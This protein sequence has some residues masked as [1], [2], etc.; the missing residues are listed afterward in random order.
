MKK[1]IFNQDI[2]SDTINSTD[3]QGKQEFSE[4][5][6]LH[7]DLEVETVPLEG[8]LLDQQFEHIVKPHSSLWKTGLKLTALLFLGAVV[9]Q[10]VQWLW[11]SFHAHQWISLAFA[12]VSFSLVIFGITAFFNEWRRLVKLKKRAQLQQDSQHF[13]AKQARFEQAENPPTAEQTVEFCLTVAKNLHFDAQSPSIELW[14]RQINESYSPQEISRLFSRNVLSP[15]DQ[16]AKKLIM[17]SATESAV[18]VAISP[19]A[20]VDMVFLGWRNLRL[21]NQIAALYGIEL[22]YFSRL[23]L[24]RMIL[25]NMAF[26]GATELLQEIGMDWLSQDITAK[27]SARAAQ[28]IGVGLLTARLGLKTMEFCRPIAFD[29][30][31]KPRLGQ[32]KTELLAALKSRLFSQNHT[33]SKMELP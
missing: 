24:L 19:L 22:G 26:A 20:I 13:I 9:A 17:K 1:Q 8:E 6:V 4:T 3:F 30:K 29:E 25:L 28:G 14:L 7:E 5:E 18:I 32:I 16:Q 2:E 15:L 33:K 12:L 27:L 11:D 31:E 21:I 10:S 23:R